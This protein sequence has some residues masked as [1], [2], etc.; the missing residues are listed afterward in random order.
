M[1]IPHEISRVIFGGRMFLDYA[2]R[3][4]SKEVVAR[5][6]HLMRVHRIRR[7]AL[8]RSTAVAQ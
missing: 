4:L 1:A 7:I 6:F 8:R 5:A 3:R 2:Y